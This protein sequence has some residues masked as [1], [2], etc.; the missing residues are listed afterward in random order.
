MRDITVSY[1]NQAV[2]KMLLYEKDSIIKDIDVGKS[3]AKFGDVLKDFKQ[4]YDKKEYFTLYEIFSYCIEKLGTKRYGYNNT[5]MA[6][7]KVSA[8]RSAIRYSKTAK[9]KPFHKIKV[10]G[11]AYAIATC[12]DDWLHNRKLLIES[13]ETMRKGKVF[14]NVDYRYRC[15]AKKDSWFY[16]LDYFFSH[17]KEYKDYKRFF[18]LEWQENVKILNTT[19]SEHDELYLIHRIVK[20]S[21]AFMKVI[22]WLNGSNF[23][24]ERVILKQKQYG[25]LNFVF[26]YGFKL[27]K[28]KRNWFLVMSYKQIK[29]LVWLRDNYSKKY[30]F[31]TMRKHETNAKHIFDILR[32]FLQRPKEYDERYQCKYIY[33]GNYRSLWL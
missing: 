9:L 31:I 14:N 16:M 19:P 25:E 32:D 4:E 21:R 23:K 12:M 7:I 3:L 10:V 33:N 24:Q 26:Q 5:K 6:N 17:L 1:S 30:P 27:I 28:V 29:A 15:Y 13:C 18:N 11:R 22:Y 2:A 8:Y 20:N